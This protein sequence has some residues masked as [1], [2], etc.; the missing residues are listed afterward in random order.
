MKKLFS[1]VAVCGLFGATVGCEKPAAPPAPPPPL[2]IPPMRCTRCTPPPPP[3]RRVLPLLTV[4][5]RPLRRTRLPPLRLMRLR[6]LRPKKSP[7]LRRKKSPPKK[8]RPKRRR[9]SSFR[10]DA[11]DGAGSSRIQAASVVTKRRFHATGRGPRGARPVVCVRPRTGS[12][13]RTDTEPDHATWN[14]WGHVRSDPSRH[15]LLAESCREACGLDEV[16]FVPAWRNPFK[17]AGGAAGGE[18]TPGKLRAEM[19]AFAI[20]AMSDS[21][22][23]PAR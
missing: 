23:I 18:A 5:P 21:R 22:S 10:G 17:S 13:E 9:P 4:P 19:I 2:R 11:L 3:V 16:R 7:L 14:L 15:L 1:L 6:P 20:A 8:S 12:A